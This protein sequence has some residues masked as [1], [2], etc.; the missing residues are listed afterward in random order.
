MNI[1][2]SVKDSVIDFII[3]NH[4]YNISRLFSYNMPKI[5][6]FS[7]GEKYIIPIFINKII[8]FFLINLF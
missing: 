6:V 5:P 1:M 2:P 7:V 3:I 4:S 8:T